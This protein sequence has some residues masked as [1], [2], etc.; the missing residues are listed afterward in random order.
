MPGIS[1]TEAS[2]VA[3]SLFGK[4]QAPLRLW[5]PSS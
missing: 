3:D 1:I 5:L 4:I 2:G